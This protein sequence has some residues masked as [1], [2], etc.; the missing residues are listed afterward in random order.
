MHVRPLAGALVVAVCALAGCAAPRA[1][2]TASPAGAAPASE[3]AVP[4]SVVVVIRVTYRERMALPPE[5]E[6]RMQVADVS[7]ADAAAPVVW[8]ETRRAAGAQVPFEFRVAVPRAR[9]D[10]RA[11]YAASA[12][13]GVGGE[14]WFVTDTNYPVNLVDPPAYD[15]LLLIARQVRREP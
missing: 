5:A 13:I 12:R 8:E 2:G 6:V 15:V 14:P 9:V 11:R 7:R 10:P 3:S 4:D 1:T